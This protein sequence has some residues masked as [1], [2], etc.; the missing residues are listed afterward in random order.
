M[1]I[2][3][4]IPVPINEPND[5]VNVDFGIYGAQINPDP[6]VNQHFTIGRRMQQLIIRSYFTRH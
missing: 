4:N 1:C 5:P 2:N 3:N 6:E